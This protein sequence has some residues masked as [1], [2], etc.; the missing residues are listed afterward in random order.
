MILPFDP[1]E[2]CSLTELP[3]VMCAHCLKH[4]LGDEES[5]KPLRFEGLTNSEN[6]K[7]IATSES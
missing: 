4:F 7:K 6:Y 3:K 1:D 5:E 2:E